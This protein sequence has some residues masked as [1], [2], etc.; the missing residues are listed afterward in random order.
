MKQAQSLRNRITCFSFLL[1]VLVIYVHAQNLD[2]QN[3]AGAAVRNAAGSA[4][5]LVSISGSLA[6]A[7]ALLSTVLGSAAVPGFFLLS[8]FQFFRGM[9]RA[10]AF[11]HALLPK[12]TRRL[13]TLVLPYFLWNAIYYLLYVLMQRAPLDAGSLA[14][15][16]FCYRYNP[17]FWYMQQLIL[18]T[19]LTPLVW[20]LG[21]K[22]KFSLLFCCASFFLAAHYRI[23]P[24]HLV[25]E[26]AFFYYV[27]GA[28]LSM[29]APKLMEEEGGHAQRIAA[30]AAGSLALIAACFLE[31]LWYQ[32]GLLY[33]LLLFRISVPLFL[34][35]FLSSFSLPRK[36]T[37]PEF[38]QISFFIYAVHFLLVRAMNRTLLRLFPDNAVLLFSAYLLMPVFCIAGAYAI[39]LFLRHFLPRFYKLLTGGR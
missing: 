15:A 33:P 39:S 22:R 4:A 13:K 31:P 35:F 16:L 32:K 27:C 7:E 2:L 18:L 26:D 11:F 34:F 19:L 37:L 6:K 25:N 30:C 21:H 12:W 17:V 9:N 29:H 3:E 8:A 24:F 38:V 23:L 20:L 10:N 14:A 36:K 28:L 5:A 1:T